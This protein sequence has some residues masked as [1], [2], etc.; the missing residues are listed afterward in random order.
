[1]AAQS[2]SPGDVFGRWTVLAQA[3]ATPDRHVMWLCRCAC[4]TERVVREKNLRRG[5]SQSC[6]CLRN[7]VTSARSR[8]HGLSDSPEHETWCRMFKRCTSIRDRDATG[9]TAAG[10]FRC[11]RRGATSRFYADMGR[12][13]PQAGLDRIDNDGPYARQLSV[14]DRPEQRPELCCVTSRSATDLRHGGRRGRGSRRVSSW[15]LRFGWPLSGQCSR[16]PSSPWR[17][18]ML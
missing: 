2:I 13:R 17:M 8:T 14:G 1:M 16:R 5:L 18:V 4:L 11:A 10:A 15:P 12:V 7:E 3:D 6:G 9:T